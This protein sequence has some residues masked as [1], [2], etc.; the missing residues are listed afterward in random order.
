M[1]YKGPDS[2]CPCHGARPHH[3]QIHRRRRCRR[4]ARYVLPPECTYLGS[5]DSVLLKLIVLQSVARELAPRTKGSIRSLRDEEHIDNA[6]VSPPSR[7]SS[8]IARVATGSYQSHLPPGL[9]GSGKR[10][11]GATAATGVY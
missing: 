1:R 9:E 2:S 10:A 3:S 6:S 4:V 8:M 11:T 5:V 7:S